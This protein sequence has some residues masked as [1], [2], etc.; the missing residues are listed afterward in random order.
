MPPA[1]VKRHVEVGIAPTGH[2]D[3]ARHGVIETVKLKPK[4]AG[5]A[6]FGGSQYDRAAFAHRGRAE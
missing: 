2:R 3:D 4:M 6:A 1:A 5:L